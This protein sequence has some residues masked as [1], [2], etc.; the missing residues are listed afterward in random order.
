MYWTDWGDQPLAKIERAGMDGTNRSVIINDDI[1]WPNGIT[2]D[3]HTGSL[4]WCD[5]HNE[6]CVLYFY[7][8]YISIDPFISSQHHA[9]SNEVSIGLGLKISLV[10]LINVPD[11]SHP[12]FTQLTKKLHFHQTFFPIIH[13]SENREIGSFGRQPYHIGVWYA[14]SV[15]CDVSQRSFVLDRLG[16]EKC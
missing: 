5:A 6:V 11:S 8:L 16:N 2:I 15:Q 3:K 12:I 13:P 10:K 9:L 4:I 14:A 7:G 1:V